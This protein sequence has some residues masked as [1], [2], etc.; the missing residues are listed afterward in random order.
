VPDH[1]ATLSEFTIKI[2]EPP[3]SLIRDTDDIRDLSN[4]VHVLMLVVDFETEVSMNGMTNFLGNSTGRYARE[5]AEA[6]RLIG[7]AAAAERLRTIVA[8]GAAAG[9]THESIQL[10]RAELA[11]YSVASFAD[12]HGDKWAAAS[13]AI[14]REEEQIVFAE[15]WEAMERFVAKHHK[16]LRSVL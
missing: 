6:L 3:L 1:R 11:P 13:D 5:T 8:I 12:V 7:C 9:M 16:A 14:A 4:P 2:Y 10:E 15:I